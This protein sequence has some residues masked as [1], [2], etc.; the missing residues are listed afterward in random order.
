VI[1]AGDGNDVISGGTHLDTLY[2]GG[3]DDSITGGANATDDV[4]I[5]G[6]LGR[7]TIVSGAAHEVIDA[8]DGDDVILGGS[9]LDTLD[10]GGGNDSITGGAN[11]TD[12]VFIFGGLGRDT[13]VSGAADDIID[14]GDDDDIILGG[15][16]TDTINGGA[17]NDSISGSTSPVDGVLIFGG[18]GRDTI[19]AGTA[20][21]VIAAG[22]GDDVVLGGA[23]R[24]TIFGDAGDDSITGGS[25][26]TDDDVWIFGGLG[27]DTIIGGVDDAT[28]LG[29]DGDDVVLG[30][31]GRDSIQGDAG[32]DLISGGSG[33]D[34][35]IF[36]GS[37][38]D[39]ILG[40]GGDKI[41]YG[42]S[43]TEDDPKFVD[44]LRYESDA[45]AVLTNGVLAGTWTILWY[46]IEVVEIVG[47][48]A[49]NRLDASAF[50]GRA[51]LVGQGG[52]DT[53]LGGSGN[54]TLEGGPGDD[55]LFG[56]VGSDAYV[57]DGAGLGADELDEPPGNP[58]DTLDFSR[59]QAPAQVDL[60]SALWQEISPGHL[61]LKLSSNAGFENAVGTSFGDAIFGNELGNYLA[62]QGGQDLL[63]GRG[64]DDVLQGGWP[65]WVYLDFDTATGTGEHVY[66][67]AE[68]D[69]IQEGMERDF[70][71]FDVQ[72]TQALPVSGNYI[73]VRFNETPSVNGRLLPGG[74]SPRVGWRELTLG[75]KVI[76]DVNGFFGADVNGLLRPDVQ[77]YIALSTTI[78]SHEL[79]HMYGLRHHD[80]FGAPGEGLFQ[81]VRPDNAGTSYISLSARF[82]P[83]Y[84]GPLTATETP[85]HL[86]ASPASVGSDIVDAVSDPFFGERDALKLS[87]GENGQT[88]FEMPDAAKQPLTVGSA[89]WQVQPL[90]E[91]PYLTVP[92]TIEKGVHRNADLGVAAIDVI[93]SIALTNNGTSESDFYSLAGHTGDVITV[94]VM[95]QI[96]RHRIAN[97]IDS[98]LRVY[99]VGPSGPQLVD[100]YASALK[101]VNDD[102][103]ERPDAVLL[104]LIL[105]A[106]GT[107]IV[108]VD[109]FKYNSDEFRWN[110]PAFDVNTWCNLHQNDVG[111]R[112]NDDG[113]YELFLYRFD[114]SP[115]RVIEDRLVGGPGSDR[116]LGN[117]G[118]E[119]YF[120]D[121]DDIVEDT[122]GPRILGDGSQIPAR[123]GNPVSWFVPASGSGLS[124]ALVSGPA[125]ATVSASTGE[126]NWV[127]YDNGTYPVQVRASNAAGTVT[128]VS[129]L[130]SSS[131]VAPAIALAWEGYGEPGEQMLL[132][133]AVTDAAFG[134]TLDNP[135][136]RFNFAIDWNDGS[137]VETGSATVHDIGS[138]G[139][140]TRA[141]FTR[142]HAY[143][144]P[145]TYTVQVQ[146]TDD[147]GAMTTA[148]LGLLVATNRPTASF[149]A[150]P[151]PSACDALVT[152]DA[153]AS[154][155]SRTDR[156]IVSYEWDFDYNGSTFTTDA[157]GVTVTHRY[158]AFGNHTAALRVTDNN[159]PPRT[160]L[161]T[162]VIEGLGNRSPVAV[163]GGPYNLD[164]GSDL[165]LDGSGS[166]DPDAACGDSIV[167]YEWDINDAGTFAYSGA[168]PTIPWAH[169]SSLPRDGSAVTVRLRVTDS[170]DLTATATT[171]LYVQPAVVVMP[172]AVN[173]NV[174]T[175]AA[176][177]LFGQLSSAHAGPED[178]FVFE[179][180]AGAG[181]TDNSRFRIAGDDLFLRRGEILDFETKPKYFVR[182]RSTD[183][184]GQVLEESIRLAV[185]NLV[186]IQNVQVGDGTAQRSRVES[187][188]VLFDSLVTMSAG[189]LLVTKRGAG[190]GAVGLSITTRE[191]SGKTVADLTFS[192]VFTSAG[193][194]LDGYYE[195]RID[196]SKIVGAGGIGLDGDQ[197]G[198]PG[199]DYLFGEVEADKFFRLYGDTNSD[200]LVGIVEFGQF[201]A[202][203]GKTPGQSGYDP[204]F[205]YDGGGVGITDFGQF[206]ARFGK[207]KLPWG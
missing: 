66:A 46:G 207:P 37:G 76:V 146:V 166:T 119:V 64:G 150:V 98:V 158:R 18:L 157:T 97:P 38:N 164:S 156:Q 123:E 25:G 28:I 137:P 144:Q 185:N 169:L 56:G 189:A 54:D 124:F 11:A 96:L 90:G 59:L 34:D 95:S 128:N 172:N 170:F 42:G 104:D 187:V 31:S 179:L 83:A 113:Q 136:E 81:A 44:T 30:G 52:N 125:G 109:T 7:D 139:N 17:G 193:S 50:S 201:R 84:M 4:Y 195:L 106:D 196:A 131:N 200:G 33:P 73:T 14:A 13:I 101:A 12:D 45:D 134:G 16:G 77:N 65:R 116:L 8:G 105:P 71:P 48:I 118:N 145:G 70:A 130:V 69:A 151:N 178:Q 120:T 92:N 135:H 202:T 1:E 205:D 67:P 191:V 175:Q 184:T 102:G 176:D 154:S 85:F 5:F 122:W 108:E 171:A 49:P 82:L 129:F 51:A 138:A 142:P 174:S 2:G 163:P 57:F 24:D 162:S 94:E 160:A 35:Q 23:D 199:G 186:E 60:A 177:L 110:F 182:V 198:S 80:A 168:K 180:V 36:G 148:T 20:G 194:L 72:F 100:Y 117:S 206:R 63:E 78:A 115:V 89:T 74:K 93:G 103:F 61:S 21:E 132:R 197:D 161:A 68:R 112:D 39:T 19:V 155:H 79:A 173:E 43:L 167:R 26:V 140:P 88:H 86:T 159:V 55:F 181:D 127:V 62:G 188:S 27:N 99:F 15:A 141:Q 32:D 107:Y 47:G 40:A 190:G 22:D 149:T 183:Q 204:R 9:H 192:G 87:F 126:V 10:G 53:L 58:G 75:G 143:T 6:G 152:L 111:C 147:D 114:N 3:G 91:L 29:G 121:A 41:I 153:S 203:F 165:I 133:A